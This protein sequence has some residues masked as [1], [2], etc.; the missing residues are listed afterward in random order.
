M[1]HLRSYKGI[2]PTLGA[3]VYVDPGRDGDWRCDTG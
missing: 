3:R 2:V 1:N